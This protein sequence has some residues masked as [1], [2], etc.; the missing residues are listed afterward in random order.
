MFQRLL[1]HQ[2][3]AHLIL[4]RGTTRPP[5]HSDFSF[6]WRANFWHHTEV[7]T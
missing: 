1:S 2:L 3:V 6:G 4:S 7:D 5:L